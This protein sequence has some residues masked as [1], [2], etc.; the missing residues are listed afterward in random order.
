MNDILHIYTTTWNNELFIQDF[1]DFYRNKFENCKITIYDNESTDN[2]VEICLKNNCEV[3]PFYTNNSMDELSLIKIRNNCWKSSD[4]K[5]IIVCD[6]DEWIDVNPSDL[7]NANW[8]I[9]KC[10]GYELVGN[11]ETMDDLKYGIPS[12][13]YSKPILFLKNE[14][15]EMNFSQGNHHINPMPYNGYNIKIGSGIKLYHTKFRNM[16]YSINRQ[17]N[18][19][20]RISENYLEKGWNTHFLLSRDEHLE[21]YNYLF[22]NKIKIR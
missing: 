8:N 14:I 2:T 10:E 7:Q 1:I 16:D 21:Y 20:K 19:G 18:I 9:M 17:V 13:I 5:F 3:I 15:S 22:E 6:S 4:S 11:D 12:N